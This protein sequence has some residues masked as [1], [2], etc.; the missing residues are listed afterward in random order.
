MN[1]S[2]TNDTASARAP[3]QG[4]FLRLK[5]NRTIIVFTLSSNHTAHFP[6]WGRMAKT[7]KAIVA[8][9]VS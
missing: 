7:V 3:R 8:L 6:L 4:A 1:A 2:G 9:E 5:T